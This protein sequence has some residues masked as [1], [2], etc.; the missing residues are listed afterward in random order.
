MTSV[1]TP[2]TVRQLADL[3]SPK[4]LPL[5]GNLLQMDIP[6]LHEV[7]E[8]WGDE[9]GSAYTIALGTKR[10]LVSSDPSLLQTAL[11]ER[12]DRYR[13]FSAI[14]SV[15]EE[16]HAKGVFA[17]EGAAWRPQRKLIMQA[18]A[19][20]NFR[21]YFPVL[22]AITMRL[23]RRWRRAAA[24][25]VPVD[26]CQDLVRYTVD[27]TTALAFGEDPNTLEAPG[28]VIQEHL[29]LLFPMLMKRVNAPFPWWRYFRLPSDR[30]FDR[31]LEAVLHHVRGLVEHKHQEMKNFPAAGPRNLLEAMLAAAAEPG[32]EITQDVVVANVLTLL[33]AGEDTTAHSLAWSMY[34]LAEYPDRQTSL[35]KQA[36]KAFGKASVCPR[37]DDIHGLEIF[38]AVSLEASR[39]RPVIPLLYLEPVVD[40]VL[41][42]ISVPSG[43]PLFF[44]LRPSMLDSAHFERPGEFLPERWTAGHAEVATHDARAYAQFGSGPRMCPGRHLAGTEIRLVLSMLARN[45]SIKFASDP[46]SIREVMAFTMMPSAMPMLFK[47][48]A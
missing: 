25:E 24:T 45:F 23:E 1:V 19:A 41:G 6:R 5:L 42:D 48:R 9:I 4:G 26:V 33:L 36:Y 39:F 10:V 15:S 27:V 28:N 12:P 29:A 30:R 7:L 35:H 34:F 3:P 20:T 2:S 44:V 11:R 8:G 38:E 32:S 14:E 13:R 31:S 22:Q 21:D 40:V 16:M 47:V 18:L 37:F 46:A 43:T 17:A